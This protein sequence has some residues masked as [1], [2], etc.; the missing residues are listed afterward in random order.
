MTVRTIKTNEVEGN[1]VA[2][3]HQRFILRSANERYRI[4]DVFHLQCYKN[5][6]P[7]AHKVNKTAWLITLIMDETLIPLEKGYQLIGFREL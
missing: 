1:R 6:K 3:K 5:G 7:A 2:D 4:N